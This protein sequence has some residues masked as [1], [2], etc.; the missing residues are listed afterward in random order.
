ME[1]WKG[2]LIQLQISA[3]FLFLFFIVAVKTVSTGR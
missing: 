2:N 1:N 3:L